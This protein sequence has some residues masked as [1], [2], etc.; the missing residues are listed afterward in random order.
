MRHPFEDFCF[1]VIGVSPSI[2]I[3]FGVII[4]VGLVGAFA[5][6]GVLG[7][8]TVLAFVGVGIAFIA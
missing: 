6:Y 4:A 8:L 7:V 1:D 3:A 5:A 2:A